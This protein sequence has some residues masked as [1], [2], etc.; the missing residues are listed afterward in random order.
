MEYTPPSRIHGYYLFK[1]HAFISEAAPLLEIDGCARCQRLA[2]MWMTGEA[3]T[4]AEDAA[5]IFLL[6]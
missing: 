5:G 4:D 2:D 1:F 3:L 6:R